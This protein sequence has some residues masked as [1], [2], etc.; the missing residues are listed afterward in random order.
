MDNIKIQL[1]KKHLFNSEFN[2]NDARDTFG[3]VVEYLHFYYDYAKRHEI[4]AR[5]W[6]YPYVYIN[7]KQTSFNVG[8]NGNW[9]DVNEEK[10]V[11]WKMDFSGGGSKKVWLNFVDAIRQKLA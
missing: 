8:P 3:M 9:W 2:S 4:S 6:T 11:L 7:D 1:G 10:A 5:A